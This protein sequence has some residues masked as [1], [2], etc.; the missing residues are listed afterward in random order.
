MRSAVFFFFCLPSC[1]SASQFRRDLCACDR[2]FNSII[3]V[4]TFPLCGWCMLGDLLSPC[5][6]MHDCTDYTSVYTL[7]RKS[8]W[9]MESEAMLTPRENSPLPQTQR[10]V[11]PATLHHTGQRA[12]GTHYQLSSKGKSP[13]EKSP[14]QEVQKRLELTTLLDAGQR[15]QHTSESQ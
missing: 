1:S 3:E 5:D 8:L 11:E 13:K 12:T 7:I 10:R 9:G 4:A 2:L 15:A 6:G 14:L